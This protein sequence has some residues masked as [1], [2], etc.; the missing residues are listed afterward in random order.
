T[1]SLAPLGENEQMLAFLAGLSEGPTVVAFIAMILSAL[2][3]SS[4]AMIIIGIAFITSGVFT[5]SAVLPLVLGAN[6]GSTLPVVISSL[7]CRID[8]KSLY[9]FYFF[10]N[11]SC[12]V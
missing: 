12:V 5:L 1:S 3:H 6:A 9:I 10:F 8:G 11:F 4:A 2:M 7:A